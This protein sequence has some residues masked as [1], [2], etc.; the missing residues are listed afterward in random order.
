MTRTLCGSL[1]L[2]LLTIA[3]PLRASTI[4]MLIR[5]KPFA[6]S[7]DVDLVLFNVTVLDDKGRL[8]SGLGKNNFRVYEDNR[9]QQIHSFQPEDVPATVGLVIDNSGSMVAKR[10]AVISA[11]T[12][13]VLSSNPQD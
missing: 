6:V 5:Q 13:F 11:A 8:V 10:S 1:I 3:A 4:G 9:E 7:V 12:E 2:S